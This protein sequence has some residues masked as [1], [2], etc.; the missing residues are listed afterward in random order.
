MLTLTVPFSILVSK[1]VSTSLW[2]SQRNLGGGV[3]SVK[4]STLYLKAT[5]AYWV[6]LWM[7][8]DANFPYH[9]FAYKGHWTLRARSIRP[10]TPVWLS[11]IFICR[12]ERYFL[13]RRTDLVPFPLEHILLDKMLKDHGKVAVL[14]AVS[15]FIEINLTHTGIQNSSL[16]ST[17]PTQTPFSRDESNLRTFLV[18]KY[19]REA[20]RNR[21]N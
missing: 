9:C 5:Y 4:R 1:W 12:M 8:I 17:W 20:C 10:N 13:L 15:C 18:G 16:I 7:A 14:S 21:A 11:E 3:G 19:A 6:I 2:G